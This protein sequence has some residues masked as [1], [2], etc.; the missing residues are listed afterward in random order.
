MSQNWEKKPNFY[1]KIFS[2]KEEKRRIPGTRH[3]KWNEQQSE[4]MVEQKMSSVVVSILERDHCKGL[5]HIPVL[6]EVGGGVSQTMEDLREGE[7]FY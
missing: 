2:L 5:F 6:A 4:G 7:K 3:G 1:F